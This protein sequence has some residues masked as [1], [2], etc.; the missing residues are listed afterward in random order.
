MFKIT[1]LS[2]AYSAPGFRSQKPENLN[3]MT[4][5]ILSVCLDI[6]EGSAAVLTYM[7]YHPRASLLKTSP[8]LENLNILP[9][10]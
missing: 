8:G 1:S 9:L 4:V 10:K 3:E 5:P 7:V 2:T 6:E